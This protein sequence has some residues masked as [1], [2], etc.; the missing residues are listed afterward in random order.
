MGRR[1]DE[2]KERLAARREARESART[3]NSRGDQPDSTA[4]R[5]ADDACAAAVAAAAERR[6]VFED[7]SGEPVITVS[8]ELNNDV[9]IEAADG[10]RFLLAALEEQRQATADEDARFAL[11]CWPG[12]VEHTVTRKT[13]WVAVLIAYGV[14]FFFALPWALLAAFVGAPGWWLLG[15][16]ALG[17]LIVV[18]VA[19]DLFRRRD[20]DD[21]SLATRVALWLRGVGGQQLYLLLIILMGFV[22]P[23]AA[24]VF[25]SDA[26]SLVDRL[27]SGNETGATE[28]LDRLTLIGR[29]LQIVF[30][31]IASLTPALLFFV[32]DREHL[33]TLRHRFVRQIMRFDASVS[34]RKQ[35]LAKY[36][37]AMDEAYGRDARGKILPSR[38]SPL[39]LATLLIAL[40][41]TFTLLH[42][43]VE[44]V[45][46]R[47]I[48][49]LFEP[50]LSAP[51]FAF[52]GA[53]FY[54][55]NAVLRGY[56]R[57]DLRAKAYSALSVRI[58]VVVVLA[59][60]LDLAWGGTTLYV[61]A[62]L[63]G[64]FPDT[65]LVL[66][67]E[68]AR[69]GL[70]GLGH[71]L[72][73]AGEESDPLTKLEGIDLYDVARFYDEGVNNVQGLAHADV[74]E[75]MLQTRIPVPRILDWVDQAILYVHA[76]PARAGGAGADDQTS[77]GADGKDAPDAAVRATAVAAD[78]ETTLATLR[79]YGIRTATDLFNA[80]DAAAKDDDR[81]DAFLEI[82]PSESATSRIQVMIDVLQDEEWIAN[83]QQWRSAECATPETLVMQVLV[84]LPR[85]MLAAAYPLRR[86]RDPI[87]EIKPHGWRLDG[88]CSAAE[89]NERLN[90]ALPSD[91]SQTVAAF[92]AGELARQPE[93]G[94]EIAHE[95]YR[96]RVADLQ[97]TLVGHLTVTADPPPEESDQQRGTAKDADS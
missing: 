81:L 19:V 17:G 62:F 6:V 11:K 49:T 70:Q 83:L 18:C 52:L 94:D 77:A 25:A 27:W 38:R 61:L 1:L 22:L 4:P 43:D 75:L 85:G 71:R 63:T 8:N 78:R 39:L 36:G 34:T 66:I 9:T 64:I 2:Q 74:V 79:K 58:L 90:A 32:F 13:G 16:I 48:A 5:Q 89:F 55:L 14:T 30:V 53:Y 3:P 20:R 91:G 65:A 26:W 28:H 72:S 7:S 76:G 10:S 46:E 51:S 84:D 41:W 21:Q 40:G 59:W 50:R 54:G 31:G 15:W 45:S 97:D 82:L 96:F 12:L 92:V 95:G 57:R 35:V 86:L 67:R 56:V 88:W 37:Q 73:L 69:T 68:Q 87:E 60:V 44:L 24:I 80:Y 29:A 23:A 42:G 33:Q 93:P 47:G